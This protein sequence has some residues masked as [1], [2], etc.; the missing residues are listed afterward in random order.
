MGRHPR[1]LRGEAHGLACD[2]RD[3]Q[4]PG[5]RRAAVRRR[6]RHHGYRLHA[7]RPAVLRRH[8]RARRPAPRAAAGPLF[9]SL[10]TDW[11]ALDCELLPWSAKAI[12]LIK[13][14]YA[15][16]GAA[17]RRVLPEALAG[18]GPG[19]RT[20]P[21]RHVP[22]P[23]A[24]G[25]G[26][27]TPPPSVTRTPPTAAPPTDSTGSRSRPSRSWPARAARSRSPS[28]TSGT[29]PS[30]RSSTATSSPRPGTASST[31][32]RSGTPRSRGGSR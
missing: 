25:S 19:R 27:P 9:E 1:G 31:C 6:R 23:P 17:A 8:H 28:R 4:G 15:S 10:E 24:H 22:W 26:S 14:Q 3:R 11:L 32:P 30:W 16:V 2:R 5:S 21:R 13:A 20:R 29:S 18:A 7:H 12:D